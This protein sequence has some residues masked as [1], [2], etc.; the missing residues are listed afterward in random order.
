[1]RMSRVTANIFRKYLSPFGVTNSQLT[2]LFILAKRDGLSQK[3]LSEIA[4]LEKSSL[5][6]NLIRLVDAGLVAKEA[7]PL[8]K[9]TDEGKSLVNEV[10]PEWRK[11]MDEIKSKLEGEGLLALDTLTDK[12][13][14]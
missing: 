5:H 12:L 2:L 8:I 6:R 4:V 7:F 10:I 1:M 11:A 9:I 14:S 13:L 3:Q